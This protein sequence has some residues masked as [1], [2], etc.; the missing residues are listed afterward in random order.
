MHVPLV[1]SHA[2]APLNQHRLAILQHRGAEHGD[3]EL[4]QD[5]EVDFFVG[6]VETEGRVA[7][8]LV[9]EVDSGVGESARGGGEY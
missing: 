7:G 1:P 8:L 2:L 3:D 5:G 4:G 6:V 9:G